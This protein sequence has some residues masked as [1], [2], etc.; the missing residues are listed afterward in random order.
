VCGPARDAGAG[1]RIFPGPVAPGRVAAPWVPDASLADAAGVVDPA[2][3]WAALDCP[4]VFAFGPLD[5]PVVLGRMAAEIVA[6]LRAGEVCVV[7]GWSLGA[8][9]RK[10]TTGTALFDARG[11]L[12]GRAHGT[13]IALRS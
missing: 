9:G 13:W 12:V 3:V 11:A 4:G 2:F 1:L 6:P 8:E 5:R 7:V 10:Y